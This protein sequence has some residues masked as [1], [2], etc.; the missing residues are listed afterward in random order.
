[1]DYSFDYLDYSFDYLDYS[2]DYLD[3]QVDEVVKLDHISAGYAQFGVI[4]GSIDSSLHDFSHYV[5][6]LSKVL[7]NLLHW[8]AILV[9]DALE[10]H[11]DASLKARGNAD[12][13]ARG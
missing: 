8:G 3:S 1:L 13:F 12:F 10:T 11:F 9:F 6:E 5:L 4:Y 2:F 7:R